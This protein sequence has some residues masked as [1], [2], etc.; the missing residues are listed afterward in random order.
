VSRQYRDLNP[1]WDRVV[2]QDTEIH[3]IVGQEKAPKT[4]KRKTKSC[5]LDGLE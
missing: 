3:Q 4:K 5:L 1:L 2:D